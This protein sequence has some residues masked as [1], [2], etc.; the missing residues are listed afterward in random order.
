KTCAMLV[1][2]LPIR[3]RVASQCPSFRQMSSS[4]CDADVIISGGGL[5]GMALACAMGRNPWISD[6]KILILERSPAP[7]PSPPLAEVD[8]V[9]TP[10]S[11]RVVALNP[12]TEKFL[13]SINVWSKLPRWQAVHRMQVWETGSAAFINFDAGSSDKITTVVETNWLLRGMLEKAIVGTLEMDCGEDDRDDHVAWQRFQDPG[14]IALLPLRHGLSS[15]V[16]STRDADR[17]MALTEEEF[18]EELNKALTRS[19]QWE[20]CPPRGGSSAFR[21]PPTVSKVV[22][23]S[24][25]AYPLALTM[26]CS[27]VRPRVVLVG[28]AAHQV[29]P[30][31]GLGVNLGF[32]DVQAL[33]R[34]VERSAR[35]GKEIGGRNEL[36]EYNSRRQR[37]NVPIMTAI[38]SLH[39]L[40]S[41]TLAPLVLLRSLGLG[42]TDAAGP[43]KRLIMLQAS[44]T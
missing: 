18:V 3:F 39:R 40:Y 17:L 27:Y 8:P 43:L 25:A 19:P 9:S 21:L 6:K 1:P 29:H 32:G 5:V 37:V 11:N 36:M 15:L 28:D 42:A 7:A 22:S 30:M 12:G 31:A 14:P 13:E 33:T 26:A 35:L 4:G 10:Y 24:R 23:G 16:W 41:T 44:T 2:L 20:N 38:D 34:A